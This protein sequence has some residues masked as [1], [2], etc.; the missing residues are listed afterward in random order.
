VSRIFS[1]IFCKLVGASA[2]ADSSASTH[3]LVDEDNAD[4]LPLLCISVERL[5][6]RSSLG[7]MV[8]NK[9]VALGIGRICNMANAC[10][11]QTCNGTVSNR[12]SVRQLS[13]CGEGKSIRC[14]YSSSPIT[15]RN[16][17]SYKHLSNAALLCPD[18]CLPCRLM[19]V[20][21]YCPVLSFKL[22]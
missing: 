7:F 19:L 16:C 4:V 1:A 20:P 17:L 2:K 14:T 11:K 3:M 21:P 9:E 15:A 10:K 22:V 12:V 8:A 5:F 13:R 18:M 6:Y